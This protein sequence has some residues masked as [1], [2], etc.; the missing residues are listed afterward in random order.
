M[1]AD[2][3]TWCETEPNEMIYLGSF[4]KQPEEKQVLGREMRKKETRTQ[5]H[6]KLQWWMACVQHNS[7]LCTNCIKSRTIELVSE[8][9]WMG[10]EALALNLNRIFFSSSWRRRTSFACRQ[11]TILTR[12]LL[13]D[14]LC[15]TFHFECTF[16]SLF[17]FFVFALVGGF[18]LILAIFPLNLVSTNPVEWGRWTM[19]REMNTRYIVMLIDHWFGWWIRFKPVFSV[20]IGSEFDSNF[21]S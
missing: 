11:Y 17:G 14:W 4:A 16:H 7:V 10:Y 3:F 5:T 2:T 20:T 15:L 21:W 6:P 8:R 1:H 13:I 9:C 19:N 12:V 18:K